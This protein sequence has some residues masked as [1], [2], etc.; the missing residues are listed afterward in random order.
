MH[1]HDLRDAEQLRGARGR[2]RPIVKK[3]ADRQERNRRLGISLMSRM[4]PKSAVSPAK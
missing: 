3:V 2:F 4:S 1:R